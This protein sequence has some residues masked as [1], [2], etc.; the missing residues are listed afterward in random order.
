MTYYISWGHI[1]T[2]TS[3]RYIIL[4]DNTALYAQPTD[5]TVGYMD[6]TRVAAS[7]HILSEKIGNEGKNYYI[8]LLNI[9]QIEV[10]DPLYSSQ[11]ELDKTGIDPIIINRWWFGDK[12]LNIEYLFYYKD[13]N[14]KHKINLWIDENNPEADENNVFVIL[15]HSSQEENETQVQQ[16]G[17][18]FD[19]TG[20]I[21]EGKNS[22]TIH[23]T[24]T[25]YKG[26]SVT[27][28]GV[29]Q[30]DTE[31][32]V[33]SGNQ[34]DDEENKEEYKNYTTSNVLK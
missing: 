15:T 23:M 5:F 7:Y 16:K 33:T 34:D 3:E 32:N 21:P 4:D 19:L 12:Y 6:G 20:L 18:S 2:S 28:K 27:E 9:E 8:S 29:F 22:I 1:Y 13:I 24:H 11:H 17:I 14:S 25:D 30:Y 10:K 26:Y 31:E